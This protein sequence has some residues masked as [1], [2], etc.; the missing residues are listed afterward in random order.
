MKDMFEVVDDLSKLLDDYEYWVIGM[1]FIRDNSDG[2]RR[3]EPRT[4]FTWEECEKRRLEQPKSGSI[5]SLKEAIE[6]AK[7]LEK[8]KI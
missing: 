4:G 3:F 8:I 5:E 1:E 7:E 2:S 6:K